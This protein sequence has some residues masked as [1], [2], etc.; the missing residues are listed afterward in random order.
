MA[1]LQQRNGSYRVIFRHRG[2]QHFVPIGKVAAE[3]AR[4]KAAQVEYLLLRLDQRLIELPPGVDIA[5]FVRFD[6]KTL[7]RGGRESGRP[8]AGREREWGASAEE[9]GTGRRPC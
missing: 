4:A 1:S 8:R 7:G 5:E 6:G 3:E 9:R 2:K